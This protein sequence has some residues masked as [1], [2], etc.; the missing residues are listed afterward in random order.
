MQ[1]TN[2]VHLLRSLTRDM[3][4]LW[5]TR[6]CVEEL[7]QRS[8]GRPF[9]DELGLDTRTGDVLFVAGRYPV[10]V[11]DWLFRNKQTGAWK[12]SWKDKGP[13]MGLLARTIKAPFEVWWPQVEVGPK[14]LR[15]TLKLLRPF[16][17]PSEK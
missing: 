7:K 6:T 2:A 5:Q 16:R 15:T 14:K 1:Q 10:A 3:S 11:N 13:Y 8:P 9:F 12:E 17:L 4:L